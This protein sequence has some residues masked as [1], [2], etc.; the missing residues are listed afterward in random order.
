[1]HRAG[2]ETFLMNYYRH[3]DRSI[4]QFDFLCNKSRIGDYDNE[5]KQMGGRIFYRDGL[6]EQ[7]EQ[8][9]IPFWRNF[10][11][12][13]PEIKILHAHNGAKQVFP[14]EGARLAG[15]PIRISHA[16]STDFVH[17]TKYHHRLELIHKISSSANCFFGCSNKAGEF[18]YGKS[19]WNNKGVIVHNAIPSRIFSYNDELRAEMRSRLGINNCYV[20]GHVGR[21][22]EQKNHTRLIGIFSKIYKNNP[23]VRL[24][25]VGAGELKEDMMKLAASLGVSDGVLFVGEQADMHKWYQAMDVFVMPS[26]F[27]GL[28]LSGIEAQAAGLPCVFS[29]RVSQET[30]ITSAVLFVSLD[31]SDDVWCDK[32]MSFVD[33]SRISTTELINEAGY[34]ISVEAKK[35]QQLYVDLVRDEEN[36]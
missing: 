14:L 1:M 20:I 11:K 9:Y 4:V 15:L 26:H 6:H 33:F 21:F 36:I 8:E 25:L 27:E 23:G 30:K 22:M 29:D 16:H 28:T 12:E 5:I 24:L 10:I 3:I 31:E 34:D 17:D 13:H 2:V 7:V 35:L 19:I 32:I 18:F